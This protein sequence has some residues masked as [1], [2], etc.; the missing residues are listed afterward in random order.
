MQ[1]RPTPTDTAVADALGRLMEFWGFRANLGRIWTA[2]YLCPRPRTAAELCQ[3]L[4]LSTGSVSMALQELCR[5]GAVTKTVLPGDRHDWYEARQDVL[6]SVANV[7]QQREAR[8][9]DQVLSTVDAALAVATA[10]VE[11]AIADSDTTGQ[12]EAQWRRARLQW[13]SDLAHAG[14]DLLGLLLDRRAL[15]S[16]LGRP[17]PTAAPLSDPLPRISLEE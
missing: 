6:S 10:A 9:I 2:L 15:E 11:R 5:W 16:F 3:E 8:E 13:L 12:A 1:V 17:E 7:M 4:Q 14:H